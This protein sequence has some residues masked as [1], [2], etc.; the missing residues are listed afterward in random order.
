MA[1]LEKSRVPSST[2]PLLQQGDVLARSEFE[3]RYAAMP[4]LKKAELIEGID[5]SSGS[6]MKTV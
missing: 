6:R 4:G 1:V 5:I 3:R 2:P